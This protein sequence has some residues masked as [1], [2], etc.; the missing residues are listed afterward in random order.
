MLNV[1]GILF[2]VNGKKVMNN[3]EKVLWNVKKFIEEVIFYV[4]YFYGKL[5]LEFIEKRYIYDFIICFVV[6]LRYFVD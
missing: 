4:I 1:K 3:C 2:L 5:C 6:N